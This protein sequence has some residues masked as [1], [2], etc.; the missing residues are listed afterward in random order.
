MYIK[1]FF[2]LCRKKQEKNEYTALISIAYL[3]HTRKLLVVSWND[4]TSTSTMW[5]HRKGIVYMHG[6]H[7]KHQLNTIN[8]RREKGKKKYETKNETIDLLSL[9]YYNLRHLPFGPH[10]FCMM[11]ATALPPPFLSNVRTS[12]QELTHIFCTLK[13]SFQ[14]LHSIAC[15]VFHFTKRSKKQRVFF[16][17]DALSSVKCICWSPAW[18]FRACCMPYLSMT[19]IFFFPLTASAEI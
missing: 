6:I 2:C 15:T 1:R 9:T 14:R 10:C 8:E 3:C 16:H 11:L 17:V 4:V 7:V 19:F 13:L 5:K 18:N 12:E